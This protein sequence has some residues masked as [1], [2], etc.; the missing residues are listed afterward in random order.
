MTRIL[1]VATLHHPQEL[2]KD[3]AATPAGTPPPLFPSSMALHFWEKAMRQQNYVVD[4]FWRNL[5]GFGSQDIAHLQAHKHSERLTPGKL[6][7]AGLQRLPPQAN[8]DYRRRNEKLIQNARAFQPDILWL[9]GDN[10]VIYPD[11]LATIQ[12]QT[13]CK[14]VYASGTSPI[15][16]SHVIER[17][18]ARL[19]DLVL[20]NDYYHGIQWLELGAKKMACLPF[21]AID[22]DFHQPQQLSPDE[23]TRYQCDVSFVGTLVPRQLYS[24]RVAA[25]DALRDFQLGIWSV[26]DIP[27][28][29]RPFWRG[30]AL[31]ASMLRVLSG[32]TICLNPHGDFMRYGG[33]MRLFEAAAVGAFQIVDDR[34]GVSAWFTPDEH[35]VI[36]ENL[37]DLRDKVAYFLAHPAERRQMADAARQHVLK[38]HTYAVRLAQVAELL[39]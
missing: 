29:L 32:A 33:N 23:K 16:F 9:M 7:N 19:Y 12:Q 25:L 31:G 34:P 2:L 8:P 30:D 3:I 37:A 39:F 10:T 38:H 5:P 21:V 13:G 22:P 14:I 4:V 11:T 15:V 1:F 24:E 36:Y 27:E 35:L 28:T 18:A 26:H 17:Q 6:I 20:V